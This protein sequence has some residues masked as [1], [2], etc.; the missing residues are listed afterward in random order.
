MER[1][2]QEAPEHVDTSPCPSAPAWI[3]AAFA[4]SLVL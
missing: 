4:D 1:R 3:Q 2:V